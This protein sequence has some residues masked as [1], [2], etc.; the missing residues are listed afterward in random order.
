MDE[1][2][3]R[4]MAIEQYL[5]GKEPVSIY[6]EL[7]RTKPWF[8]KWLN[9]YQSGEEQ[10]FQGQS[11]APHTSPHQASPTLQDLIKKVRIQL[12]ENPYAQIGV[13]AIKWECTKLGIT[14]PPDRT[15]NR[16]LQRADLLK[17]N[18]LP[19]QGSGIPLLPA[20]AGVQQCPPSRPA[21][22]SLYQKRRSLLF[23]PCDRPLQSPDLYPSPAA[24][25]RRSG[26]S[27][28][29]PLL[30]NHGHPRLPSTRQRTLF[31]GQQSASPFF[32]HRPSS[33][34][35][36]GHRSRLYPHRR[37]LVEW[38]CGERAGL[39]NLDNSEVGLK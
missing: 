10:W 5:H 8:F 3:L 25:R 11:R 4:K 19:I 34:S 18:S 36:L 20:T 37:T 9:R 30:E 15:I 22:T 6:Q 7:G 31:S 27:G 23:F 32:R 24:Q 28:P 39:E 33:L 13:S 17:K 35:F 29:D 14:P 12:E 2:T 21:G 26:R 1:E 16:I 38:Y